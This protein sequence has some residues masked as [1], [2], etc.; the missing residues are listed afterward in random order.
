MYHKILELTLTLVVTATPVGGASHPQKHPETGIT[1]IPAPVQQIEPIK[2]IEAAPPAPLEPV[3]P[4]P[5]P[6]PVV[7]SG[8]DSSGNWYDAGNCTW[9]VKSRR[10]DLPN[11]LGNADTWTIRA[12]YHG[13]STGYTAQVGAVAQLGM[14]VVY[15]EAVSG[16]MMTI[17]EMNYLG[18]YQTDT[19]T[20]PSAGWSFIY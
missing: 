10:P 15:V 9:Y 17:S 6:A 8:F 1:P 2:P 14:H 12:A 13:Y 16:G 11:D 7:P 3:A 20:I 4:P 18:L 19:R 5:P